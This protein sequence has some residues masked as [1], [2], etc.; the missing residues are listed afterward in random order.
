M[1]DPGRGRGGRRIPD[2]LVTEHVGRELRLS[3]G[4]AG[5][6]GSVVAVDLR[7][8]EE[9]SE[10][11]DDPARGDEDEDEADEVISS[12]CSGSVP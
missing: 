8:Y 1:S 3:L 4:D 11:G 6:R 12:S 2:G 7:Q 9:V 10:G 5:P